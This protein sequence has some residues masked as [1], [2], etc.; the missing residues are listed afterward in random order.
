[1]LI[2]DNF[3]G[4]V[5]VYADV[6]CYVQCGDIFGEPLML[7]TKLILPLG[8]VSTLFFTKSQPTVLQTC[9]PGFWEC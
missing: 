3:D 4:R 1:M 6:F 8:N 7:L 5:Y 2:T 9:L